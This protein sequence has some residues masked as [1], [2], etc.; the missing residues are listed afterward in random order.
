MKRTIDLNRDDGSAILELIGFSVLIQIPILIFAISASSTLH[1]QL[2]IESIARHGVRSFTLE[3]DAD[4]VG[5]VVEELA[6]GF[7]LQSETLNWNLS[8]APNSDCSD[9]NG[10]VTMQV[11]LNNLIAYS[12][13]RFGQE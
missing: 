13:M 6:L 5:R 4:S 9:P 10:L 12:S 3:P 2:A 8:C 7:G 11:N 1:Q